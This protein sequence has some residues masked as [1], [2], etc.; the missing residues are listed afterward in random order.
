MDRTSNMLI[1]VVD[2]LKRILDFRLKNPTVP[3]RKNQATVTNR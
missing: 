2:M 3:N 1:N